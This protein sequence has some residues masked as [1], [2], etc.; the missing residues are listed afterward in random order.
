MNNFMDYFVTKENYTNRGHWA[1]ARHVSEVNTPLT[2]PNNNFFGKCSR[3]EGGGTRAPAQSEYTRG[4]E[5]KKAPR[6]KTGVCCS[7]RI[8]CA[9]VRT[10]AVARVYGGGGGVPDRVTLV[11]AVYGITSIVYPATLPLCAP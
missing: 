3:G 1:R 9:C 11:T 4:E 10:M 2:I 6:S 5:K 8:Q 7:A